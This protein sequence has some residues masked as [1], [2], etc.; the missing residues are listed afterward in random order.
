[1]T[2]QKHVVI[3]ANG[4]VEAWRR[5]ARKSFECGENTDD[6]MGKRLV[7]HRSVIYANCAFELE[8]VLNA[9]SRLER[10]ESALVKEECDH[11]MYNLRRYRQ[12]NGMNQSAF[13]RECP[14]CGGEQ[15]GR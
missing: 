6:Q 12:L 10:V 3:A 13:I 9:N 1:M 15:Y 11:C 4:L 8:Q 14:Y 5:R 7:E 2:Y